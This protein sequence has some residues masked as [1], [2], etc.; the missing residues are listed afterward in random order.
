M[1]MWAYEQS[2]YYRQEMLPALQPF[3]VGE[4]TTTCCEMK[5]IQ[6]WEDDLGP[7]AMLYGGEL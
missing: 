7:Y 1:E 5:V 6:A 4:F 3:F 2:D